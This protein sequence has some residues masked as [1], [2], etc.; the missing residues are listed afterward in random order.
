MSAKSTPCAPRSQTAVGLTHAGGVVFRKRAASI[1]YLVVQ[2][3]QDKSQWVLPKGHIEPGED[4]RETAV[5]EVKEETG[6][7]AR[8]VK[9]IQDL[10]LDNGASDTATVRF[11]C[12]ELADNSG[13][14]TKTLLAAGEPQT[15]M[16]AAGRCKAVRHVSRDRKALG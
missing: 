13:E 12:M 4:P 11:Y 3:S 1:E 5:R 16:A 14:K 7:W 10:R 9:W 15:S 2:A 6:Y 8:V